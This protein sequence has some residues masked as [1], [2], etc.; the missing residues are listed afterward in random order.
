[1]TRF[2]FLHSSATDFQGGEQFAK[3]EVSTEVPGEG[4]GDGVARSTPFTQQ[5]KVILTSQMN[6]ISTVK[7]NAFPHWDVVRVGFMWPL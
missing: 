4:P 6:S 3:E 1:M 2:L 7:T 5:T